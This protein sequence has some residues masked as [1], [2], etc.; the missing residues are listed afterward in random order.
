[1]SDEKILIFTDEKRKITEEENKLTPE[2]EELILKNKKNQERMALER[3]RNNEAVV[4]QF[5][6]KS[7]NKK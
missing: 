5:N 7:K 1:M 6:L 2:Q 3:K 4:R